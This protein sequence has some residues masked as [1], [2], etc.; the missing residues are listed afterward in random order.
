MVDASVDENKV[1]GLIGSAGK[2][3]ATD[4]HADEHLKR[5]ESLDSVDDFRRFLKDAPLG[6]AD[7]AK[8]DFIRTVTEADREHWRDW[9]SRLAYSVDLQIAE[10]R[11]PGA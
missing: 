6:F 7:E 8:E 9:A 1:K 10:F 2:A 5:L 4:H 3:L 11:H